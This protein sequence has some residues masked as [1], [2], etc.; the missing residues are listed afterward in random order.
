MDQCDFRQIWASYTRVQFQGL[1][2]L[3]MKYIQVYVIIN[4]YSQFYSLNAEILYV[5]IS[6]S[7][8][9]HGAERTLATV[10][11]EISW[12]G[13]LLAASLSFVSILLSFDGIEWE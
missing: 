13:V 10:K 9:M 1:F 3:N 5:C 4:K 11:V 7:R 12:E 8:L 6:S 2:D